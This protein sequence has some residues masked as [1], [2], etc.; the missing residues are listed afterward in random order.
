[1]HAHVRVTSGRQTEKTH[2]SLVTLYSRL[3]DGLEILRI[4]FSI[5]RKSFRSKREKRSLKI[6]NISKIHLFFSTR[7][8][9]SNYL[10]ELFN[11]ISEISRLKS[12]LQDDLEVDARLVELRNLRRLNK[13][14]NAKITLFLTTYNIYSVIYPRGLVCL[15]TNLVRISSEWTKLP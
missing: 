14:L 9:R 3:S 1:M 12:G 11:L 15:D 8:G 6:S 10:E 7:R 4:I 5:G 13:A 2:L